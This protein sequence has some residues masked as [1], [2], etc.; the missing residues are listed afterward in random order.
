MMKPQIS[1]FAEHEREVRRTTIGNP[2]VGL[3][4]H[5]DFEAL[6]ASIDAAALRP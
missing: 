1:L 5:V 6:A 2:L 3:T 4:K